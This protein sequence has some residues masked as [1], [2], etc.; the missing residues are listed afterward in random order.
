MIINGK[1][2]QLRYKMNAL[3][4]WEQVMGRRFEL[5]TTFDE[6]VF[7]YCL[8][9]TNNEGIDLTW[10]EFSHWLEEHREAKE[11]FAEFL[12][13]NSV[14]EDQFVVEDSDGEKKS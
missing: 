8:V 10:D 6:D 11:E 2:I 12:T 14:K 13:R 1:E 9:M 3:Y 4:T 5:N 7:L